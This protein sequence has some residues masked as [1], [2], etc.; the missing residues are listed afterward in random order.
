MMEDD[1][2]PNG[3]FVETVEMTQPPEGAPDDNWVRY[4]IG[5]GSSKIEGKKI[6]SLYDVTQHAKNVAECLNSRKD[7]YGSIHIYRK[8]N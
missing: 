6:G 8:Q 7:K 5:K 4:V 1:A 3:Y 2:N